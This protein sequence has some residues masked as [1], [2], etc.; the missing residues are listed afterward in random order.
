MPRWQVATVLAAIA[1]FYALT[2]AGNLSE[3]DDAYHF[4]YLVQHAALLDFSDPRLLGYHL[5]ARVLWRLGDSAGLAPPALELLRTLSVVGATACLWLVQRILREHLSVP[6]RPAWLATALLGLSYGCW[7][8]AAEADVYLPAMALCTALLLA[9]LRSS[10]SAVR[11]A[12]LGAGAGAVVLFYQPTAIPLFMAFPLLLWQRGGWRVALGYASVGGVVA[13]AG[14]LAAFGVY[15]AEPLSMDA[16]RQFMAQRSEEFMVPALSLWAVKMSL[17]RSVAALGHDITAANWVFGLPGAEGVVQRLFSSNTIEQELFQARQAGAL[18]Y[19]GL[20]TLPLVIAAAARVLWLACPWRVRWRLRGP[21]PAIWLW[22]TLTALIIGRLNPAG[23]E[24]WIVFLLPLTLLFGAL[25]AAPAWARGG[26]QALGLLV[27]A[28]A[29]HNALGGMA[30]VASERSDLNAVRG[31][32]VMQHAQANDLVLVADGTDLAESLRYRSP[33]QVLMIDG[34]AFPAVA[35]ALGGDM[36][37]EVHSRG[38]GFMG[39]AVHLA[40]R[41]T[42]AR[43][44]RVIAIQPSPLTEPVGR[45]LHR[46]ADGASTRLMGGP[47]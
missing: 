12:V 21:L 2:A 27:A 14:Y 4:A 47:S 41:D 19:V 37:A 32:W 3:T 1:A 45:E 24:A 18:P 42:V 46:S 33:A 6:A 35:Q 16:L 8:Y 10:V 23:T 25:V 17:L 28:L 9:L 34:F 20:L 40:A 22:G 43:G 38:R 15:W 39:V 13:A 26:G 7:R 36:E 29:V 11:A 30:L 5:L 44:G 31:A